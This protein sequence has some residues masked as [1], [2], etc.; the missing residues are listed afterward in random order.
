MR[1]TPPPPFMESQ[2]FRARREAHESDQTF[3]KE[4]GKRSK[5]LAAS[6]DV[7]V[8]QHMLEEDKNGS[9]VTFALEHDDP[10]KQGMCVTMAV[11]YEQQFDTRRGCSYER[12]VTLT[13]T[14]PHQAKT[15]TFTMGNN[16]P[17]YHNTHGSISDGTM[18]AKPCS[19]ITEWKNMYG[20]HPADH[21]PET[22]AWSQLNDNTEFVQN[23]LVA[24]EKMQVI[25]DATVGNYGSMLRR[26]MTQKIAALRETLR[27]ASENVLRHIGT[28]K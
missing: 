4:L 14:L 22:A 28:G 26:Y 24:M 21:S 19:R 5:R 8:Q 1:Y 17:R 25:L 18:I 10:A 3:S 20:V 11:Q 12:R 15:Y 13:I 23:C 7:L 27:V 16:H 9:S 2:P 6:A